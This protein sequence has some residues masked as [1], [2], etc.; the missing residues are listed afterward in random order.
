MN[1]FKTHSETVLGKKCVGLE[2]VRTNQIWVLNSNLE[3][4]VISVMRN[5]EKKN[6]IF[7]TDRQTNKQFHTHSI[8]AYFRYLDKRCVAGLNETRQ[9]WGWMFSRGDCKLGFHFWES[10]IRRK[11][12]FLSHPFIFIVTASTVFYTRLGVGSFWCVLV[13]VLCVTISWRVFW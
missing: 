7:K 1:K 6:G 11:T 9:I 3:I 8:S 12:L 4:L 10:R 13:C 2:E 5:S